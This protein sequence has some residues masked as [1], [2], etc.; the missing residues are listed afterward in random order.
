MIF[1][2]DVYIYRW[3]IFVPTGSNDLIWAK[4]ADPRYQIFLND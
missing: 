3:T 4:L 2:F 1:L